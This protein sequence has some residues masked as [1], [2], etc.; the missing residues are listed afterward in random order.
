MKASVE[1]RILNA[2][3]FTTPEEHS[4]FLDLL[5]QARRELEARISYE[6]ASIHGRIGGFVLSATEMQPKLQHTTETYI[7]QHGIQDAG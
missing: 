4:A 7:Q 1:L 6:E 2:T 3:H 5:R